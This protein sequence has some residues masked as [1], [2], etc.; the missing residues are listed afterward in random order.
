MQHISQAK[1]SLKLK[2]ERE[3]PTMLQR[4]DLEAGD[5]I[6]SEIPYR[7]HTSEKNSLD[8]Y[9][10]IEL[11]VQRSEPVGDSNAQVYAHHGVAGITLVGDT[12]EELVVR[13]ERMIWAIRQVFAESLLAPDPSCGPIIP[14]MEGYGL[15]QTNVT[16]I[17]YPFVKGAYIE[18][19]M[20]TVGP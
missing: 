4:G 18:W 2:L 5:G 20:N 13:V 1:R 11:A 15:L 19:T 12:E 3:M 9:P 17:E 14:G 7:I 6:T 8:G 10:A 16:G